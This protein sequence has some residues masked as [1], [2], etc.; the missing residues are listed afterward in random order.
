VLL[1]GN[2]EMFSFFFVSKNF[3]FLQLQ[4]NVIKLFFLLG[5]VL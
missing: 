3:L 5:P 2:E 1:T 4:Q